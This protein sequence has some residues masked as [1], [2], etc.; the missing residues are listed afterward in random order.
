M[1]HKAIAI[2]AMSGDFGPRVIIPSTL[3]FLQ[4]QPE[5]LV[6]LVGKQAEISQFVDLEKYPNISLLDVDHVVAMGDKPA[7]VLRSKKPSSMSKA[8]DLVAEGKAGA[9]VSAGN[10]GALMALSKFKLKTIPG[11]ARP[12]ICGALP[13]LT[14]HSYLLDM[15]ANVD[16]SSDDLLTFAKMAQTLVSVVEK[17]KNPSVALLNI[18]EEDSKG[19]TQV[20][21]VA[22]RLQADSSINYIGF[23]EAH[24]MYE[25]V[26]DIILCDGFVGNIALKASEGVAT[27]ILEKIKQE[28]KNDKIAKALS[29]LAIPEFLRIKDKIDP[30]R[31]NGASFLGINGIVVKSHGH[32]DEE[33]FSHALFQA[34]EMMSSDIVGRLNQQ[35]SSSINK[36]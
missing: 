28:L 3:K 17:R 23:V 11:V 6:I 29:Y 33:A 26:A 1:Q 35:F 22:E 24:K 14:S 7:A 16:S 5:L 19:N 13:S 20:K 30:R 25:G 18:G 12:A 32:A 2:D 31:F 34:L 10:T 8:L 36:D 21:A 4:S 9:C 27:Y 15:G